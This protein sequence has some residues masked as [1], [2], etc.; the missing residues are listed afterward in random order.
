MGFPECIENGFTMDK[1]TL[2]SSGINQ[3]A[4]HVDF[5]VGSDDLSIDGIKKD[6]TREPIFVGGQWI[7]ECE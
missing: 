6:G 1:D 7:W 5:M 4:I 3:S 2:I